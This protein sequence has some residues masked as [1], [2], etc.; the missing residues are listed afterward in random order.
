VADPARG[1]AVVR[2][3]RPR[4]E[5]ALVLRRA[6]P[7]LSAL[8][9]RLVLHAASIVLPAGAVV[10]CADARTGKSTLALALDAAGFPVLGDDHV[11]LEVRPDAVVVAHASVPWVE[12]SARSVRAFRPDVRRPDREGPVRVKTARP[13]PGVPVAGIVLLRRGSG[14]SRRRISGARLLPK[15]LRRFAFVGD[16]SDARETSER[17]DAALR[18]VTGVPCTSLM[19]P[20]GL[21]RLNKSLARIGTWWAVQPTGGT[22]HNPAGGYTLAPGA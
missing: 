20:A 2:H 15:L 4:D 6:L 19:L 14:L 18:L 13:R 12:V 11:S 16:P 1:V 7:Y 17:F 5:D 9:G 22:S 3:A 8:R 21:S 10:F